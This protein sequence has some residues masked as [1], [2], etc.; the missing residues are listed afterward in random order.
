[1]SDASAIL[2]VIAVQQTRDLAHSAVP[3]A[4]VRDDL[5]APKRPGGAG[6]GGP[7]PSGRPRPPPP[8][9]GNRTAWPH[10]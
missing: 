3:D 9:P 7:P 4:P 6:A 10:G 5:D 2:A 1:M 8:G